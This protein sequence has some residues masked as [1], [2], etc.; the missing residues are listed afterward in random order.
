LA[1]QAALAVGG[2]WARSR[3]LGPNVRRL[4]AA[5]ASRKEIALTFDDGP[6]PRITPSVL[7]LLDQV[8]ARAT[9]FCIGQRAAACPELVREI[10][11]RGHLV[12][13][14]SYRHSNL[15]AFHGLGRLRQEITRGQEVLG[16]LAQRRPCLFRPPARIRSFLLEP[17]LASMGL[18]L[19]SWSWRGFDTLTSDPEQIGRRLAP[20]VKPGQILLLHDGR[21]SQRGNHVVLEV[22]P[23]VFDCIKE[24]GL[25]PVSLTPDVLT[26]AE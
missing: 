5:A 25:K 4:P 16:E 1:D 26:P 2:L 8:E 19:V 17:V 18:S 12:E 20:G 3:L 15:F 14:H 21:G 23:Q 24:R 11:G 10:V 13:N 22:L 7:D 6:D 9:F